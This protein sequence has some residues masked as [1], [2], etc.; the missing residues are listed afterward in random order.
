MFWFIAKNWLVTAAIGLFL[1]SVSF[2]FVWAFIPESPKW[3]YVKKRFSDLRAV[4]IYM[5]KTNGID[6]P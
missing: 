4:M 5:A 1:V 2:I 6:L 3:L